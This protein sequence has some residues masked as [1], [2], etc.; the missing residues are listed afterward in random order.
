MSLLRCSLYE[1]TL[2]VYIN[3]NIM[4]LRLYFCLM[5][6]C[7]LLPVSVLKANSSFLASA[8]RMEFIGN[9]VPFEIPRGSGGGSRSVILCFFSVIP[10]IPFSAYQEGNSIV[11]DFLEPIIG[12]VE[13]TISQDG[14][15]VYSSS[16]DIQEAT[17]KDIQLSQELSGS[18]L[19]EIRGAN[20]ACAY[21]WFT[22]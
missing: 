16:E 4:K 10:L 11:L 1:L 14:V 13:V 3:T 9:D 17:S 2:N 19:L 21:A 20:G 6:L 15:P 5:S 8:E 22:L 18:F 12:K 7:C